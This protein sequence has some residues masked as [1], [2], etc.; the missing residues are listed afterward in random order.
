MEKIRFIRG[1][2]NVIRS[3]REECYQYLF[4]NMLEAVLLT[5]PDGKIYRANPA[6]CELFGRTEEDICSIG[7]EGLVDGQDPRIIQA[8]QIRKKTG[9]YSG[10]LNYIKKDG[11]IFP[12]ES[13]SK[14]FLDA[15]GQQWTALIIRDISQRKTQEHENLLA[16][17]TMEYQASYDYLTGVLNRRSFLEKLGLELE[18]QDIRNKPVCVLMMDLDYFK[19]INDQYGHIYGDQVLKQFAELVSKSLRPKDFMGRYGGDEFIVY[20]PDTTMEGGLLTA[21]RLRSTL[22]KESRDTLHLESPLTVSIG[23]TC[24]N[25]QNLIDRDQLLQVI[26]ENMYKAKVQRNCVFGI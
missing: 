25:E 24:R 8:L 4:E 1:V 19:N 20:L 17:K 2:V 23:V 22:E 15:A 26:D 18:I 13:S 16:R 14:V 10:E 11:T 7:R 12:A 5:S 9:E 3:I 6:A 21:E